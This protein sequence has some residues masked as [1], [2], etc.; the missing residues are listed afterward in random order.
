MRYRC[1][2]VELINPFLVGALCTVAL[3]L[4]ARVSMDA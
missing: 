3:W 2:M 1:A 4:L